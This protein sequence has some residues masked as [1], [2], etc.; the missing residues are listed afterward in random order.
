MIVI[1][2]VG[3]NSTFGSVGKVVAGCT[4]WEIAGGPEKPGG[5]AA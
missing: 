5:N 4:V 2:S 1:V 3:V